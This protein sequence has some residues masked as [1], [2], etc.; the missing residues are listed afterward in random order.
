MGATT[1]LV[2][3][4]SGLIGKELRR[5]LS[6]LGEQVINLDIKEGFDLRNQSL[7]EYA[8]VDYVWFLAWDSGGAKFLTN[9][10]NFINIYRNSTAICNTVFSFIEKYNKSFLFT[11]SQ[12]ASSDTP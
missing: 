5:Q 2:L 9:E 6:H 8:Y 12:L 3:G 11:S 10:K 7:E 1:N 4:G